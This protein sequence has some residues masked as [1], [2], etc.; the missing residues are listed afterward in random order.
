ME[1]MRFRGTQGGKGRGVGGVKA[2]ACSQHAKLA[3]QPQLPAAVQVTTL[4]ISFAR[5]KS[6]YHEP[7]V[8]SIDFETI[9]TRPSGNDQHDVTCAHR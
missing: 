2:A 9:L 6:Y 4:S 3:S 7:S 1:V 8:I 5:Y